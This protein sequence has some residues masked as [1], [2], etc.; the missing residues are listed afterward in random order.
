MMHVGGG[1]GGGGQNSV[2]L[3][4]DGLGCKFMVDVFVR[5]DVAED[6]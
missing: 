4:L 5:G 3:L 6:V 1:G 2:W